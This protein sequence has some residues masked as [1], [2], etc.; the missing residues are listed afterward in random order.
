M[1]AP[2]DRLEMHLMRLLFS[3]RTVTDVGPTRLLP[4][5]LTPYLR[6]VNVI[7][8]GRLLL[9]AFQAQV[10]SKSTQ[11]ARGGGAVAAPDHVAQQA[12]AAHT[13]SATGVMTGS[14]IY[15]DLVTKAIMNG[16]MISID[17]LTQEH[18]VTVTYARRWQAIIDLRRERLKL[19]CMGLLSP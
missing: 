17:L 8:T 13:K 19:A 18:G 10:R 5:V 11:A 16:I 12:A 2:T 3:R 4:V 6:R 15:I 7:A 14:M 1:G 9:E